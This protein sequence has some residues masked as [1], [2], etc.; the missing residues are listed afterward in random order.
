MK[1]I[2]IQAPKNTQKKLFSPYLQ[3]KV[4][5]HSLFLAVIQNFGIALKSLKQEK[6]NP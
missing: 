4:L 6:G 1:K 2:T 5:H 3:I